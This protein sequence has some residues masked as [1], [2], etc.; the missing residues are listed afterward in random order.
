MSLVKKKE[1]S[2]MLTLMDSHTTEMFKLKITWTLQ[3]Q[4]R[5]NLSTS[6][7]GISG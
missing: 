4:A 3:F 1:I 2:S 7:A 6:S 5:Y